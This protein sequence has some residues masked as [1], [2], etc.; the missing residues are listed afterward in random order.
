MPKG[1]T[2][3]SCAIGTPYIIFFKEIH[4]INQILF[5]QNTYISYKQKI[6]NNKINKIQLT[7]PN[8]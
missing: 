8:S 2:Y 1:Q 5:F 4:P 3:K 7:N 6:S